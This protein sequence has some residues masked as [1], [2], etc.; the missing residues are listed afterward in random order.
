MV[1]YLLYHKINLD[2]DYTINDYKIV[3][4]KK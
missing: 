3:M 2:I 4:Y 1:S